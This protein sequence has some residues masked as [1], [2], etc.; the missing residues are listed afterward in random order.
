MSGKLV[1]GA[2]VIGQSGGP[3]AVINQ[4]LVGVIEGLRGIRAIR[5]IYGM[6]HGVDGLIK[7][8]PLVDLTGCT[9]EVL[10]RVARTPGAALGS[11]RAKPA[12]ADCAK[13]FE[14]CRASEIHYFFYIGG[15]DSSD[16]CRLVSEAAKRAAYDLRCF[17]VPKTIDN[18]LV[19]SDHTPGYGSAARYVAMAF[20][21][22]DRDNAS[23]PGIKINVVMGRN[24][25]F[26]TAASALARHGEGDG[27]HLIYLPEVPFD[28]DRFIEDVKGAVA[29]HNRCQ[30]AVSEGI[31]D[32][33]GQEIGAKLIAGAQTDAHG[34]VQLSGSGALG[35]ALAT[36]IKE[37]IKSP[38][39]KPPRVRADTLGYLQRCWPQPSH[40]DADEARGAGVFA[41]QAASRGEMEGSIA[42]ARL[43]NHPYRIEKRVL[44]LKD[45]A[46]KTKVMPP[47]FIKG[48]H[49]V[50]KEF[51]DY[52]KPLVG[53]LPTFGRL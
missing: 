32:K 40:V 8:L 31:R 47:E 14:A 16:T 43:S 10:D 46:G 28:T 24:A 7:G 38:N 6:R 42:I 3:T 49:D 11:S 13:I 53:E 15:N 1:D 41:A 17:H 50:T 2:A 12:D 4:S 34:N 44:N 45:V 26:L 21:A 22:D 48:H 19:G 51:V 18:D 36:L 29:R 52:A 39:G 30:I 35:D 9:S 23:L 20:M 33:E 25:G 5:K 27:P 37:R